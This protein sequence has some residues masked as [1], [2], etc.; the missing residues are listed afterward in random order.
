MFVVFGG[1]GLFG[2]GLGF[3]VIHF[4][5][6]EIDFYP[7]GGR[8]IGADCREFNEVANHLFIVFVSF[9]QL[10]DNFFFIEGYKDF[11]LSIVSVEEDCPRA[12]AI[13]IFCTVRM[14]KADELVVRF[15]VIPNSEVKFYDKIFFV[16]AGVGE[17]FFVGRIFYVGWW[18]WL[19]GDDI[20]IR[21]ADFSLSK[22]RG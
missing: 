4:I 5:F 2:E 21:I 16:S 13:L 9:F 19:F 3:C 17:L 1:W 11:V 14:I 10:G 6:I 7:I 12:A 22:M 18:I 20:V 8:R 15:W